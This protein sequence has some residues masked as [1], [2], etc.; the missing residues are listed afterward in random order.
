MGC[1]V[2]LSA[3][4]IAVSRYSDD[5]SQRVE[6]Q[7]KVDWR[8]TKTCRINRESQSLVNSAMRYGRGSRAFRPW[9]ALVRRKTVG[10]PL[11]G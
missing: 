10:A 8:R 11:P 6:M 9:G 2:S 3:G 5:I 1:L 4:F 7:R